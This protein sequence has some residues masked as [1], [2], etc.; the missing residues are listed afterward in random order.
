MGKREFPD[1]LPPHF[2][3]TEGAVLGSILLNP[4]ESMA[5]CL[6]QMPEDGY[7]Y[8]LRH[9][10]IYE[11]MC[12]IYSE[13]KVVDLVS[14]SARLKNIGK[15]DEIGGFNYITQL[16]DFSQ[17]AANISQYIEEIASKR[18]LRTI[19]QTCT[20][21]C[22]QAYDQGTAT[23]QEVLENFEKRAMSL[24]PNRKEK[25]KEMKV[26]VGEAVAEIERLYESRGQID[27]ISTGLTDL[28]RLTGGLHDGEMIVVAGYPS[29]GKSALA[30]N[31]AECVAINYGLPVGIFSLEMTAKSLVVRM[32]CSQSRINLRN[33]RDGFLAERDFP[34]IAN[35]AGKLSKADIHIEDISDLSIIQLR[36]IARRM[37]QQHGIRLAVID[38]LQLL[39]A[40]GGVRKI[41]SRQQE[42]TDISRGIKG[43]ALELGIPVLALSQLND[44]GKLRESRAIG[45]DADVLWILENEEDGSNEEATD[46]R[47]VK[48]TIRKQR[49]G[50]APAVVNLTFL[51]C[52]TRF[53]SAAKV[54]SEDVAQQE[55]KNPMKDA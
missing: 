47:Q 2:T 25:R 37:K 4:N 8:D 20:D 6:E 42:V 23:A 32:V 9:Q 34:R 1:R 19:I 45:Q 50:P 33:V 26:L 36:S 28:D 43:M 24:M 40:I 49:N 30:S 17:S 54:S 52:Y 10:T 51:K 21:C 13:G 31:I 48:L 35:A 39:S 18:L 41:E 46:V 27:G 5:A 38:Y 16:P 11:A 44:D 15:L 22:A 7:F 29:S 55:F 12:H 14:L 3:E 53:E